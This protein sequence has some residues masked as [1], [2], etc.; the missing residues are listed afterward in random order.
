MFS[1]KFVTCVASFNFVHWKGFRIDNFLASIDGFLASFVAERDMLDF[2]L[3]FS[4]FTVS[5]GLSKSV[6]FLIGELDLRVVSEPWKL[7][8]EL[9][10]IESLIIDKDD[11]S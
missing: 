4:W 1:L 5:A 11:F 2:L 6:I 3:S 10:L 7:P 9:L 8:V